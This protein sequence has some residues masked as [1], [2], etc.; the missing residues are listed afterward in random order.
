MTVDVHL[1]PRVID[2][3]SYQA[4][5]PIIQIFGQIAL[6][7]R[8]TRQLQTGSIIDSLS[9]FENSTKEKGTASHK[10]PRGIT[11]LDEENIKR[12]RQILMDRLSERALPEKLFGLE[13]EY[14]TIL[15]LLGRTVTLGESNTCLIIGPSGTGKTTIV[16]KALQE[17]K[18]AY[19]DDFFCIELNGFPQT[20][21]RLALREIVR[22]L[23]LQPQLEG[24]VFR[25]FA[26]SLNYILGLLKSGNKDT[27]KPIIFLLDEFDLFA[28]H[29][30]QALL[31]NLFDVSQSNQ[32]PIAV[33]GMTC[34]LN[35]LTL[36]EK[37]VKSRFSHRQVH[38]YPPENFNLYIEMAKSVIR[39]NDKVGEIDQ[40]YSDDFNQKIEELFDNDN[41][42][43]TLRRI[44][45]SLRGLRGFY[46]LCFKPVAE[47]SLDKK[48]LVPSDFYESGMLQQAEAK[49][50]LVKG[51]SHLEL[52]LL[53]AI[54]HI[55]TPES[56]TFNFCMVYDQY[57]NFM[58]DQAVRG[59]GNMRMYK[60]GVALKSFEHLI[61]IELVT[62]DQ[63]STKCQK[64]YRMMRV[65]LDPLQITRAV[66]SFANCPIEIQRWGQE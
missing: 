34:R 7:K 65:M 24:Q 25:S 54:K 60:W 50:E 26:D 12:T 21:D 29:N 53:I 45:D 28:Q 47:L 23:S 3:T 36:L 48:Y 16:R 33:I 4:V 20:N 32:A 15:E 31:Y 39:L 22:Q 58:N 43:K 41:F 5:F 40:N 13:D 46:N 66:L 44:F 17:L 6:M 9:P 1:T 14:N 11:G 59:K 64:E 8:S 51:L 37:R 49:I 35:A 18:A 55:V 63:A 52:C 30:K 38:L 10:R 19:G 2:A 56:P 61:A 57:K 27:S 62:S 42:L